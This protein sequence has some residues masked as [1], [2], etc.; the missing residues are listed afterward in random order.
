M[1]ATSTEEARGHLRL[2]KNKSNGSVDPARSVLKQK[3]FSQGVTGT[4]GVLCTKH[5]CE[6]FAEPWPSAV[7]LYD[8]GPDPV[9][10]SNADE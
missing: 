8:C 6:C 5:I 2:K 3:K 1:E 10:L 4:A 9:A 7:L